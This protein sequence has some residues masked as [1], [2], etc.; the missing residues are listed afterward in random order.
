MADLGRQALETRAGEGDRLQQLGVA[1]ARDD[2]RGDVLARE[3]QPREH[4]RLELGLGGGIGAD[5]SRDRADRGLG[6]GA[7]RRRCALRWAS[8]AKPG[9]LDPERGRLGVHAVG[10]AD[11]QR[12]RVLARARG[13]RRDELV[14]RGQDHLSDLAQLQRER[15][16]EHVGAG[17]AKVDPAPG[18]AGRRGEHVDERGRCRG[19]SAARAH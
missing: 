4:A 10:P 14:G 8:K 19:R 13:E 16:V 5:G 15:G 7:A 18:L 9:E 2:L 11:A 12:L 3:S 6:E 17:Q 1:V